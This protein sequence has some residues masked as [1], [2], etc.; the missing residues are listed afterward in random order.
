VGRRETERANSEIS[1]E[2]RGRKIGEKAEKLNGAK[3]REFRRF[4][5][6]N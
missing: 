4:F 5:F 2:Y 1:D 3:L 6:L